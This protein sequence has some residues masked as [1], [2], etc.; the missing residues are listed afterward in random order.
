MNPL[1]SDMSISLGAPRDS[2][3][4]YLAMVLDKMALSPDASHAAIIEF[5][6]GAVAQLDFLET[7]IVG[8]AYVEER[9]ESLV[10]LGEWGTTYVVD[11]TGTHVGAIAGVNDRGPLRALRCVDNVVLAV[12]TNLQVY[13]RDPDGSWMNF[14][15]GSDLKRS[16]AR[17]HLEAIDGYSRNELYAAG[18]RGIIWRFDG[19]SWNPTETPTN[20]A[21]TDI[22]CADD[23]VVYACGQCGT[24]VAGRGDRFE[25]VAQDTSIDDLWGIREFR[26]TVYTATMRAL[27][28]LNKDEL[29]PCM[30]AMKLAGSFYSLG[31]SDGVL[32]SF[33][34][35][36]LLRSNGDRWV[37]SEEVTVV[38]RNES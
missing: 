28:V 6:P 25:L 31:V 3:V 37:R 16:F 1:F 7:A 24:V 4:A 33:G 23:G 17:N 18:R 14:G 8:M 5:H 27:L 13:A 2:Q 34:A 29:Q 30:P 32:W 10:L 15:P 21:L 22:H 38:P 35:K 26:G 12:G 36:D 20:L 11:A 9:P 19:S